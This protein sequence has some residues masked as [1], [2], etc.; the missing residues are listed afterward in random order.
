MFD[1]GLVLEGGG[2]RGVYTS[3]V[4]EFFMEKNLYFPY[5]IGVSAGAC[6][7]ASYLSRQKGRNKT[8]NTEFL[9]NPDYLS[10]RNYWKKRQLFGMDFI[11]N[12]LPN[13]LVPFDFQTFNKAKETFV[14]GTTDCHTGEAIYYTNH[15]HG[16][17][18]LKI[19]RA[20]SSL[21]FIAP[22]VQYDERHLLDGGIADPLP[23]KQAEHDGFSKNVVILTRN[24]GYYK[25]PSKNSWLAKKL[26]KEYPGLLEK[27]ESRANTYNKN[28]DY[29]IEQENNGNIL[30][31]QPSKPLKVG[32]IER[33]KTKLL[34]LFEE[35]YEDAKRIYPTLLK[36]LES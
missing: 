2:M 13:K 22:V 20:S 15:E 33:N 4:L 31:I 24:N 25:K 11:F 3:G 36:W 18:I 21:P 32:R 26:Y 10:L 19:L 35:G 16:S 9:D 14:V 1:T 7:A 28:L 17:D 5:I 29:I 27:L 6:N 34:E 30:T 8:V 12:D 23:I